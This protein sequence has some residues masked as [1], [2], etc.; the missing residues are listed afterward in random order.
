LL[1]AVDRWATAKVPT[2]VL[3]PAAI[4]LLVAA[5]EQEKTPCAVANLIPN[6]EQVLAGFLDK[7]AAAAAVPG[8]YRCVACLVELL[9]RAL[10][11]LT[12]SHA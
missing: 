9:P 6:L 3:L 7:E 10:C 11:H 12:R 2:D 5:L 1:H 8:L 4:E